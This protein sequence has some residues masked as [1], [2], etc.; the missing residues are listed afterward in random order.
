MKSGES[1]VVDRPQRGTFKIRLH[2]RGPWVAAAIVDRPDGLHALVNGAAAEAL[3]MKALAPADV[4]NFIWNFG[5]RI[6]VDQYCA[7]VEAHDRAMREAPWSAHANPD[8]PVKPG[9]VPV[10]DLMP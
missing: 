7:M 8:M 3:G 5:V 4:V 1:R 6:D 10:E 9:E 2:R